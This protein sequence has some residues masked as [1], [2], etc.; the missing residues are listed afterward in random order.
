[1]VD[2]LD[3][4]N[5]PINNPRPTGSHPTD[6]PGI[7]PQPR[8]GSGYLLGAILL[9]AIIILGYFFYKNGERPDSGPT[10]ATQSEPAPATPPA[11]PPAQN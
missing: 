7:P 5:D 2:P 1:M 8:G 11:S 9:V 10:P 4:R 6:P 3:P